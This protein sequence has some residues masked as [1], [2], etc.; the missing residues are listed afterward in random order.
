MG[1]SNTELYATALTTGLQ[2]ERARIMTLI[3]LQYT[4]LNATGELDASQVLA[5][6]IL[7][8][9]IERIKEGKN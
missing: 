9:L 4:K 6:E 3:R 2:M 8:E 5:A 1:S 7:D